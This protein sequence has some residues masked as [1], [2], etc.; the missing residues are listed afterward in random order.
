V[1]AS[2]IW[3]ALR[4]LLLILGIVSP[5]LPVSILVISL[6]A[7]LTALDSRRQSETIFLAN[8]GTPE[9]TLVLTAS[10]PPVLLEL[11]TRFVQWMM[12]RS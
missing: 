10:A 3:F 6:T 7:A 8:L 11:L 1:R 2:G 12:V 5:P 9:W 4:G